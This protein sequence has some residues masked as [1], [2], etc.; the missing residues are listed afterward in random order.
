[1]SI[2]RKMEKGKVLKYEKIGN[3]AYARI[4]T[5]EGEHL[6]RCRYF[7]PSSLA[8]FQIDRPASEFVSLKQFID[9]IGRLDA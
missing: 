2:G 1:M 8:S 5:T 6:Y 7:C 4:I 9:S 3:F